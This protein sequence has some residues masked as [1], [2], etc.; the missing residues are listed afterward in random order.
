MECPLIDENFVECSRVLSVNNLAN[1][2]EL[3][4]NNY[5]RCT[6]YQNVQKNKQ[7]AINREKVNV[8]T[9]TPIPYFTVRK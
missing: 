6:F 4:N 2:F 3:C 9:I 1:A 5:H 7:I 8:A